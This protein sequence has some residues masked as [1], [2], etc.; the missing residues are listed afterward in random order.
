MKITDTRAEIKINIELNQDEA[1][2]L[3]EYFGKTS[4]SSTSELLEISEES[5]KAKA[6]HKLL[7]DMYCYLNDLFSKEDY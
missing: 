4:K 6:V 3:K 1:I 5:D 7:Y 2:L